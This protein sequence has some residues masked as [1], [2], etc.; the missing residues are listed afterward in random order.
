MRQVTKEL[1][2]PQILRFIKEHHTIYYLQFKP[3]FKIYVNLRGSRINYDRDFWPCSHS[4]C[5]YRNILVP[6]YCYTAISI[7]S[8]TS[9]KVEYEREKLAGNDD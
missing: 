1:P 4:L 7:K 8:N 9:G 3:Y 6:F 2:Y 5:T